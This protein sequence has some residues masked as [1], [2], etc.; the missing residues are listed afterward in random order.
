MYLQPPKR[1]WA[2]FA[3]LLYDVS[4]PTAA[5]RESTPE[6]H[7]LPASLGD[8]FSYVFYVNNRKVE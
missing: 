3:L 5:E 2:K 6:G 1:I 7:P 4:N 8:R